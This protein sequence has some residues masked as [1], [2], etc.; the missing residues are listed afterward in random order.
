[1]TFRVERF[2]D[3]PEE[4]GGT[5][6]FAYGA[7]TRACS[8][9]HLANRELYAVFVRMILAFHIRESPDP[10]ARPNLDSIDC[11]AIPTGLVTQPKPFRV[12]LEP[13]NEVLLE[14]WITNSVK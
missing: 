9:N 6:H 7:G 4:G 8:G 10:A 13:R 12:L 5:Q 1:M 2:L 11:S 3:V 14:Q